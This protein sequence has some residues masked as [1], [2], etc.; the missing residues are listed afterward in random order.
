LQLAAARRN[1]PVRTRRRDRA[2]GYLAR[3]DHTGVVLRAVACQTQSYSGL[4]CRV[5]L[6]NT[7]DEEQTGITVRARRQTDGETTALASR[8]VEALDAGETTTVALRPGGRRAGVVIE[9]GGDDEEMRINRTPV[10]LD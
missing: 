2:T 6:E 10:T 9:A 4:I 7:S 1:D 3:L 5:V 8:T